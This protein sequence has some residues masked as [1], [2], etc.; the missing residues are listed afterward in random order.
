MKKP[1]TDKGVNSGGGGPS[2]PIKH[3]EAKQMTEK[4]LTPSEVAKRLNVTLRTVQRWIS[5]GLLSSYKIGKTRRVSEEQLKQFLERY[6]E[7][8]RLLEPNE[9]YDL[10][11]REFYGRLR[12]CLG[13]GK[14]EKVG[15][16]W[17]MI[18]NMPDR[19]SWEYPKFCCSWECAKRYTQYVAD[20]LQEGEEGENH[21]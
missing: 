4:L 15:P 10:C 20:Q 6:E 17:I 8:E 21:A 11:V 14:E 19:E 16:Q 18:L 1:T 13:C 2:R 3:K 5:E 9:F 7:R 12:K